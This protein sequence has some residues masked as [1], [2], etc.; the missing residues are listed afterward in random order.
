MAQ[1]KFCI[2]FILAR[3]Y[4]QATVCGTEAVDECTNGANDN[5]G[6][7]HHVAGLLLAGV[8]PG[9]VQLDS[10]YADNT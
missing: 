3:L 1:C 9:Y 4:V 7:E 5:T 2:N 6:N 8:Y 10:K